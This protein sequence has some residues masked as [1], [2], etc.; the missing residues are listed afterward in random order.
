[1][2]VLKKDRVYY[3][4][5]RDEQAKGLP[6]IPNNRDSTHNFLFQKFSIRS[7]VAVALQIF[8]LDR[9]MCKFTCSE[10]A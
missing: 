4:H 1:M 6:E 7:Y 8:E 2:E 3:F 10:I 5:S 9:D